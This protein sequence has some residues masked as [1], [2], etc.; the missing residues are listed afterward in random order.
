MNVGVVIPHVRAIVKEE[1]SHE[2]IM[3]ASASSK[4]P[5]KEEGY[6]LSQRYRQNMDWSTG[7]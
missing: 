6:S 7:Y 5:A 2:P 4:P 1:F 3:R